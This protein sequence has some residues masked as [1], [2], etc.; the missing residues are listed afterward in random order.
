VEDSISRALASLRAGSDPDDVYGAMQRLARIGTPA[1]EPLIRILRDAKERP[2]VRARAG[3][4]L[5]M[6]GDRRA[7]QPLID[8]LDD[9]DVEL[10]WSAIGSLGRLR[11]AE[12]V[13]ALRRLAAADAGGFSIT[14]SLHVTV[15]QAA[16]EALARIEGQDS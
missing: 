3:E 14:T 10:R 12:A 11:A 4:S 8:V 5:E 1:V 16:A 6:I 13:P 2:V 9:P 7:V 15:R